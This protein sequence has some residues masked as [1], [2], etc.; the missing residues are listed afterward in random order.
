M[1]YTIGAW[2]IYVYTISEKAS[3]Q[4]ARWIEL[5][6]MFL[7]VTDWISLYIVTLTTSL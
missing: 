5:L 6:Y 4:L 3:R 2:I 1:A 7:T